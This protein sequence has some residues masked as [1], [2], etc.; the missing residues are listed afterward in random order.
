MEMEV[1]GDSGD[2][3]LAVALV[4]R[5]DTPGVSRIELKFT[6]TVVQGGSSATVDLSRVEFIGSMGIRMFISVARALSKKQRRLVLY[7]AQPLV[8]DVFTMVSLSDII[9]ILPDSASALQFA[10]S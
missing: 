7:G 10:R 1:L 6:A 8:T 5:L 9:P 4:G 2:G 3:V